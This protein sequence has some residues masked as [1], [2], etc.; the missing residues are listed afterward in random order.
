MIDVYR[1][2]TTKQYEGYK[3][4]LAGSMVYHGLNYED[5]STRNKKAYPVIYM[6]DE[7]GDGTDY[8]IED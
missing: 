5:A 2:M 3:F 7:N 1:Y 6:E 4:I 8:S